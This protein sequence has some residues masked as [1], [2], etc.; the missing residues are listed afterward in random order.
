MARLYEEGD[1]VRL[2]E[3]VR[4]YSWDGTAHVLQ[5]GI[6]GQ[7]IIGTEAHPGRQIVEFPLVDLDAEGTPKDLPI[8][9]EAD[10]LDAQLEPA[11][12]GGN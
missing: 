5:P 10:L 4:A 1:W 12:S 7:V 2:R 3:A 8:F 11:A 9:V 6:E